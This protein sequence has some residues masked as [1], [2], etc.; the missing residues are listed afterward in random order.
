MSARG[1]SPDAYGVRMSH[2]ASWPRRRLLRVLATVAAVGSLAAACGGSDAEVTDA[3]TTTTSVFTSGVYG[4]GGG[5]ASGG[6]SAGGGSTGSTMVPDTVTGVAA[7]DGDGSCVL[8]TYELDAEYMFDQII[9]ASGGGDALTVTGAVMLE[10]SDDGTLGINLDGWSFRLF[11]PGETDTVLST[12]SGSLTG[13][14]EVDADGNHTVTFTG[15]DTSGTFVLE[16]AAGSIPVPSGMDIWTIPSD[17]P[18]VLDC[19]DDRLVMQ[20]QDSQLGIVV[21]WVFDRV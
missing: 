14:W 16:T 18:L 21:D 15:S 7:G 13:I 5:V 20:V 4:G 1:H 10:V 2:P 17:I 8:G 9:A 11:F 3:S 6:G 19:A 12:Q